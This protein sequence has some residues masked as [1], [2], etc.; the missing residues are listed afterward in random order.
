MD[1]IAKNEKISEAARSVGRKVVLESV[2][3]AI[4]ETRN[5]I[6]NSKDGA[7]GVK[8]G[9][10]GPFEPDKLIEDILSKV[11]LKTK[12]NLKRVVNATGIIIHTNLGRA[13]LSKEIKEK[14]W[15]IAENYSNLEYNVHTGKRGSR[16]DHVRELITRLTG[17]QSSMVVNNN[18]AAVLLVLNTLAQGAG[19]AVSR[20]E[21]VE[22]GESFRLPEILEKSGATLVEVGSTNKTRVSDYRKVIETGEASL[23]L[24]VNPGNYQI[25]GF[26]EEAT[27][28]ELKE[29]GGEYGVPVIHDLGSGA[30]VELGAYGIRG[31]TT[32]H[33]SV[34]AGADITC[35]SGDKLL[36]GPQAGVIAG[37]QELIEKMAKNPLTRA[38][39]IDKLTLA[40]LE[41]TLRLY[42]NHEDA[43]GCIP[44]LSMIMEPLKSIY[45]RAKVLCSLI[46][47]RADHCS[48]YVAD[49]YSQ[50]GGGALPLQ[51]LPTTIIK[52]K[53][54]NFSL[55]ELEERLRTGQNPV[56]TRVH[57][58]YIWL[59]VRTI[60]E[61]EMST[62]MNAFGEITWE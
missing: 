8:S 22:L 57:K 30:L 32:V 39:R 11:E 9:E 2:R 36:G 28:S 62:V 43:I 6:L 23:I 55:Q 26:T 40:A 51:N 20:G 16:Y 53:P 47:S 61:E 48:V 49:G 24:K 19:V 13:L 45:S 5:K 38:F 18:A 58:D 3:E 29:L 15:E 35:F 54:E 46:R 25:V 17:A 52:V 60:R 44:V 4:D 21:L 27:I 14:V 56:I 42:L 34:S 1:D 31:E 10:C 37:K 33:E 41:A 12:M 7:E 50:I 59:D